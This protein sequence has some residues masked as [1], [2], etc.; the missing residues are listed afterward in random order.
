[1]IQLQK[2]F[3]L[4]TGIALGSFAPLY[5]NLFNFIILAFII[6]LFFTK[7]QQLYQDILQARKY[8]GIN[9]I[10]LL[11]LTIHSLVINTQST[12]LGKSTYG[13]FEVVLLHFILVPIYIST[14]RQ[15]LTPKLLKQFFLYFCVACFLFNLYI[16][17]YWTGTMLFTSP[18]AALQ[19]IL[20][21]RFGDNM[22]LW[23]GFYFLEM[24]AM[25]IGI[26]A[27]SAYYYCILEKK[28]NKK[29]YWGILCLFLSVFLI[30]TVTKSAL[31]G[32]TIGFICLSIYLIKKSSWIKRCI[33]VCTLSSLVFI[34]AFFLKDSLK[35]TERLQ[36]FKQ[37]LQG[38]QQ[39]EFTG[40]SL[41]PRIAFIQESYEHRDEFAIWGLGIYAQSQM[42]TWFKNSD[43]NI[44]RFN[45]VHNSFLQYW[46]IGG[47]AGLTLLLFLFINPILCIIKKRQFSFLVLTL[48]IMMFIVSCSCVTMAR[49]NSRTLILVFLALFSFY[50][51]LFHQL[52]N[53]PSSE[54][55]D[56]NTIS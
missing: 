20:T 56:K 18:Q 47:I 40:S 15:W 27:L 10:F 32:F 28:I 6:L 8:I 33:F 30:F 12:S 26:A 36:Q 53:N 17:F 3:F 1:M 16:F 44:A 4:F 2:N 52:E 37:E 48:T 7:R 31:I 54:S 55:N 41:A 9:L 51:P 45:N 49:G 29:I 50:T 34:A 19:E 5:G 43:K 11:Y 46:I 13:I 25:C 39:G 24:R 22:A 14:L 35:Y 42:K 21:I 38:V 23:N